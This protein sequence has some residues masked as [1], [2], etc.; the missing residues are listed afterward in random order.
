VAAET[1]SYAVWI[2]VVAGPD[3]AVVSA[4][5]EAASLSVA[6]GDVVAVGD[7][8]GVEGMDGGGVTGWEPDPLGRMT[9][10]V[11]FVMMSSRL[12]ETTTLPFRSMLAWARAS[13]TSPRHIATVTTL[14]LSMIVTSFIDAWATPTPP[15]ATRPTIELA[16]NVATYFECSMSLQGK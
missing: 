11:P 8:V 4:V 9:T 6:V 13:L 1:V 10:T 2:T 15:S 16:T 12:G 7:P 14:P 5:A 3:S